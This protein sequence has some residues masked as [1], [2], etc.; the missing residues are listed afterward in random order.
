MTSQNPVERELFHGTAIQ[1]ANKICSDGFD[2]SFAG[3][4]G[5]SPPQNEK[6]R[7]SISCCYGTSI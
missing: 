1:D 7:I 6:I 2:R 4:N 3:K 5:M